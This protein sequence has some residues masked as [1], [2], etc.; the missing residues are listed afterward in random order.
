MQILFSLTDPRSWLAGFR[1]RPVALSS[2]YPA[3]ECIRRLA[4]VTTRRGAT[5]WYLDPRTVGLPTPR[6]SGDVG[7]SRIVVARWEDANGRGSF[8]PW[9]NVQLEPPAGGGAT[10]RGM[11]GLHPAMGGFMPVFAVVSAVLLVTLMAGGTGL[12]VHGDPKGLVFV[13][14]PLALAAFGAGIFIAGLRSLERGIPKLIQEMN[15][16][17]DSTA[18]FTGAAA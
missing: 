10:L 8:T 2:P 17:L 1:S 18:T 7:L 13:L 14:M 15:G 4:A 12:L 6:L 16:I 3:E 9:L 5:S 11:I